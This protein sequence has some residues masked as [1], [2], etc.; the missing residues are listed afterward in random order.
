MTR[1]NAATRSSRGADEELTTRFNAAT[2]FYCFAPRCF[3]PRLSLL[4]FSRLV[5]S[6][7]SHTSRLV[8]SLLVDSLLVDS[9]FVDSLLVASLLAWTHLASFPYSPPGLLLNWRFQAGRCC[10][11]RRRMLR[12]RRPCYSARRCSRC[13]HRWWWRQCCRCRC[14]RDNLC[15]LLI[16]TWIATFL[17]RTPC[18]R[19]RKLR[20]RRPCCSDLACSRCTC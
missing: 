1:L 13:T 2:R 19:R 12:P 3:A 15:T 11:R 14:P 20:P 18:R 9:L 8:D 4:V 10:R 5:D 17:V 16:L 7:D 6:L